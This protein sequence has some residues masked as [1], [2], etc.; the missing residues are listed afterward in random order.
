[1]GREQTK[2]V[3]VNAQGSSGKGWPSV[4]IGA[5]KLGLSGPQDLLLKGV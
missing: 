1:M 2:G 3:T 5:Y 4:S